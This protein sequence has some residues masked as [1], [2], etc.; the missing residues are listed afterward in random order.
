MKFIEILSVYYSSTKIILF[1][2]HLTGEHLLS[3]ISRPIS[4]FLEGSLGFKIDL[5][6]NSLVAQGAT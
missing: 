4:I 5:T 6:G 2:I 3:L 1:S